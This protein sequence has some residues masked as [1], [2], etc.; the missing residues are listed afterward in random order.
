M[1]LYLT[2][3]ALGP[4]HVL[5]PRL[6]IHGAVAV[7]LHGEGGAG[8]QEKHAAGHEEHLHLERSMGE[9]RTASDAH[10]RFCRGFY[11]DSLFAINQARVILNVSC[12][13]WRVSKAEEERRKRNRFSIRGKSPSLIIMTF[14]TRVPG[15]DFPSSDG[16]HYVR[17][18]QEAFR[19]A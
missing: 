8:R 4:L 11:R 3:D 12:V 13:I 9:N 10:N 19:P 16:D 7:W 2:K 1:L 14:V 15:L 5:L 6:L 17:E 18:F